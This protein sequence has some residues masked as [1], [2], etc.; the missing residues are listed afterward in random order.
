MGRDFWNILVGGMIVSTDEFE[1]EEIEKVEL[2][3]IR[4]ELREILGIKFM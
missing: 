1:D 4:S 2:L 3:V